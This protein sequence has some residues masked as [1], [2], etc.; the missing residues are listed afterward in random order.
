MFSSFS[1][2]FGLFLQFHS[3]KHSF[4]QFPRRAANKSWCTYVIRIQLFSFLFLVG[5][6]LW[7]IKAA[8]GPRIAKSGD[9]TSC[10]CTGGCFNFWDVRVSATKAII[11]FICISTHS[12]S[13]PVVGCPFFLLLF[14]FRPVSVVFAVYTLTSGNIPQMA[15]VSNFFFLRRTLTIK[16][17]RAETHQTNLLQTPSVSSTVLQYY[18]KQR[19]QETQISLVEYR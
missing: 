8:S 9:A 4:T 3:F 1:L 5:G 15:Q 18:S 16:I 11:L 14:D 7:G 17:F 2:L 6:G 19:F 12:P 10:R 13:G